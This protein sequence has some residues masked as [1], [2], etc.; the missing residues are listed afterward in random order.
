M[1][2]AFIDLS[3]LKTDTLRDI[4]VTSG[5]IWPDGDDRESRLFRFQAR[6]IVAEALRQGM[7]SGQKL[8]AVVATMSQRAN[9]P[10]TDR[11]RM[12]E[13]RKASSRAPAK[14][15]ARPC[16]ICGWAEH[17]AVHLPCVDGPRIGQ[18]YHHAY[19]A[20]IGEQMP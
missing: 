12:L 11:K 16:A 2:E 18:P 14:D 8:N 17:M 19:A 7:E 13:M 9:Q 15:R 10:D 5:V 3:E 6:R 20:A 4:V 1:P